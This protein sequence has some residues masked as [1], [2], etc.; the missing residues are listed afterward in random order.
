MSSVLLRESRVYWKE[1]GGKKRLEAGHS[2]V[3]SKHPTE[4]RQED[5]V[6][7]AGLDDGGLKPGSKNSKIQSK[8]KQVQVF[9]NEGSSLSLFAFSVSMCVCVHP[10]HMDKTEDRF[11]EFEI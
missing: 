9:L 3:G 6:F 11:L 5:D 4:L 8:T 2:T 1:R 10:L 7:E